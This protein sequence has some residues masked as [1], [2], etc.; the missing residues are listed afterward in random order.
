MQ[1]QPTA[2]APAP[3]RRS[4]VLASDVLITQAGQFQALETLLPDTAQRITGLY[5]AATLMPGRRY[6]R[7]DAFVVFGLAPTNG[8][9]FRVATAPVSAAGDNTTVGFAIE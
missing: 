3:V 4:R 1:P 7:R 2:P 6:H 5:A 9:D 8:S